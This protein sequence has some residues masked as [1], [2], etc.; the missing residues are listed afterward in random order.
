MAQLTHNPKSTPP[1]KHGK[2]KS[3]PTWLWMVLM[4]G[5]VAIHAILAVV[6]LPL[7]DYLSSQL[8]NQQL[9]ASSIPVE[10]VELPPTE[11]PESPSDDRPSASN[12][13]ANPPS[14][15]AGTVSPESSNS[16]SENTSSQISTGDIGFA[17]P[18]PIPPEPIPPD[19]LNVSAPLAPSPTP[20]PTPATPTTPTPPI[21]EQTVSPQPET[22]QVDR[23]PDP[24]A[25]DPEALDPN[26]LN[27][28]SPNADGNRSASET[29]PNSEN[30][31]LPQISN[32]PQPPNSPQTSA[33]PNSDGFQTF[34]ID[35]PPP[36]VSE[37]LPIPEAP[38]DSSTLA[39]TDV[40]QQATPVSLVTQVT[41][42]RLPTAAEGDNPEQLAAPRGNVSN[43]MISDPV[44]SPCFPLV[45]PAVMSAIGST[46]TLQIGTD[47]A[48]QITQ[49]SIYESSQNDAYDALAQC[50]VQNWDFRPATNQGEPVSS[51]AL[52][53]RMIINRD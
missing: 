36:D 39:Q 37:T 52:L 7:A 14:K 13:S 20:T 44:T 50:I 19:R 11:S 43:Q 8:S 21:P 25:L 10:W 22:R 45:Q 47:P 6:A 48:G 23:E 53:V 38:I 35:R 1:K 49:T 24:E 15:L 5:S 42:D 34:A 31:P 40:D 4:G 28:E 9:E 3:D 17:A 12:S 30:S 41:F 46:V 27:P 26:P 51:S 29:N 18:T 16:N 2:H 32:S 33:S